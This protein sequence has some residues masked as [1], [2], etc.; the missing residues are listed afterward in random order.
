MAVISVRQLGKE[1][2]LGT[3]VHDTLRD[4]ITAL[5]RGRKKQPAEKFW[6]LRDVSFDVEQGDCVGIIGRNGAGKSTLL[7]ILSQITEPTEGEIRIR[8]RI[9][10][11]LEVG[12]GFHPELTG[13]ENTFLNGAILGM[14]RAEITRKFDEIAAFAEMDTFLDTPVKHYSSGMTTRLA[15][16]VAAHLD[17]EI[18]IIDEVLAVGDA[19]FQK[20]CIGRMT[21]VARA[22]RTVL[23]VSHN[24][25]AV[26]AFC[27]RG[28]YLERGQL[29]AVGPMRE[30]SET[31]L[32]DAFS[33][34]G[35]FE[36]RRGKVR[37]SGRI[38]FT[39]LNIGPGTANA[40]LVCGD[41]M[42]FRF[43]Y[44]AVTEGIPA[45]FLINIH[46]QQQVRLLVID[47]HTDDSFPYLCPSTGSITVKIPSDVS[48][49]PGRYS[50]ELMALTSDEVADHIPGALDFEVHDG[51]FFGN[52]RRAHQPAAFLTK[53]A[54]SLDVSGEP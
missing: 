39:S 38:W 18:L 20:K 51:D 25:S 31:Y 40:S 54:W 24:M 5:F 2:R 16:A 34:K 7:K 53:S 27:S 8:G 33:S 30:I 49:V 42:T 47:S 52:G 46:D 17:P 41:E 12:T 44:K 48:L 28:L 35:Q 11:L 22:G 13:R 29:K 50:I 1:Y 14:T 23:F 36:F 37:G 26:T 9:A 21:E 45:R 15:F 10:S 32:A 6:A 3:Q 4:Q 43:T 19:A